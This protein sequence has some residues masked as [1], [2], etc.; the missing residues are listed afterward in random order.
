MRSD[1]SVSQFVIAGLDP[2]IHGEPHVT[3]DH[4][5][6]PGGDAV[7]SDEA[8]CSRPTSDMTNATAPALWIKDPLAILAD[9]AFDG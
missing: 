2:A 3:I 7:E 1:S 4:R 8:K 5:V 9:G 6:K